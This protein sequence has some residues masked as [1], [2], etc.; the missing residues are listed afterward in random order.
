MD[1]KLGSANPLGPVSSPGYSICVCTSL[2]RSESL[3]ALLESIAH[4]RLRSQDAI[5]V[6]VVLIS[7]C[8]PT[9]ENRHLAAQAAAL[10]STAIRTRVVWE[11]TPGIPFAR[12]T[13]LRAA[14]YSNVI[15]V[16]D[17]EVVPPGWLAAYHACVLRLQS[18]DQ[19]FAA[20]QGPVH[21]IVCPPNQPPGWYS[22]QRTKLHGDLVQ[23]SSAAT[24]NVLINRMASSTKGVW[25]DERFPTLGGSDSHYFRQVQQNGGRIWWSDSIPVFAPV[26]QI[27]MGA[28]FVLK[29]GFRNSFAPTRRAIADRDW[30]YLFEFQ[31][32]V[33]LQLSLL[34]VRIILALIA[35]RLYTRRLLFSTGFAVG[36]VFALF[37]LRFSDY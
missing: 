7:N 4:Q 32:R 1:K 3:H 17:D 25:F 16:D 37:G 33:V 36:W 8:P 20:I 12:N 26:E 35:P 29:R 31:T 14:T 19:N 23:L 10:S 9:P 21:H 22:V 15:F 27:R 5:C 6:E 28:R 18:I 11:E 30:Q 34:P 24:S 13:A 2:E